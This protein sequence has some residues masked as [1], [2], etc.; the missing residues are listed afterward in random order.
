MEQTELRRAVGVLTVVGKGFRP[1][2]V[3]RLEEEAVPLCFDRREWFCDFRDHHRSSS[4]SLCRLRPCCHCRKR[5]PV[6]VLIVVSVFFEFWE[7]YSRCVLV[8]DVVIRICSRCRLRWLPGCRRASLETVAVPVQPSFLSFVLL[9][10]LQKWLGAE[11]LVASNF[12]L[13]RK[14]L[15][16]TFELWICVLSLFYEMEE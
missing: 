15:Y 10:L 11:V 1:P 4:L 12:E 9:W 2:Q 3:S 14:G 5:L 8:S 16:E 13:R 6:R 7:Y